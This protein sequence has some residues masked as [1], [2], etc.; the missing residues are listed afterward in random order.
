MDKLLAAATE[1]YAKVSDTRESHRERLASDREKLLKKMKRLK[2]LI[3]D[4]DDDNTAVERDL[5]AEFKSM[6]KRLQN[7]DLDLQ[8][9]D[10]LPQSI[11]N[12]LNSDELRVALPALLKDMSARSKEF[13]DLLRKIFPQIDV[14]PIQAIDSTQ[15]WPR[16]R[17]AFDAS[18][19][20]GEN[21]DALAEGF[22]LDLFAPS[23]QYLHREEC[24]RMKKENPKLSTVKIGEALG[25]SNQSVSRALKLHAKM[26]EMGLD[27]PYRVVTE[28]P[29]GA[30]LA[31]LA[32]ALEE[33][34]DHQAE[35]G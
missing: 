16:A 11:S 5:R 28:H 27:E 23:V 17:V 31:G 18:A 3:L 34:A 2:R 24:V 1:T 21:A 12:D 8:G 6:K 32:R 33:S 25:I 26:L 13:S 22:T 14:F 20:G 7:L 9:I 29:I 4:S 15:M 35:R 19:L 30:A 10:A